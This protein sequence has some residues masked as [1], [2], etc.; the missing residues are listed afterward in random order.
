M[1]NKGRLLS[2][3]TSSLGWH[4]DP[5]VGTL[6]PQRSLKVETQKKNPSK[7]GAGYQSIT[8]RIAGLTELT[9]RKCTRQQD[10]SQNLNKRKKGERVEDLSRL[11][12]SVRSRHII[13]THQ[14]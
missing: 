8:H 1:E 9:V 11:E 3:K 7:S 10:P 14:P 6:G 13:S 2:S 12:S 5:Q 4:C